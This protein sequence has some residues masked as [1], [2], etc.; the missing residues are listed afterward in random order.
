MLARG[1]T[2]SAADLKYFGERR[3][4]LVRSLLAVDVA[5]PVLTLLV[6]VLLRPAPATTLGL[7]ILAASPAAPFVLLKIESAGGRREY[8]TSLHLALALLA[9]VTTPATLALL[10]GFAGVELKVSA[11]A[12]AE[13]IGVSVLLPLLAGMLVRRLVPTASS[14]LVRPLETFAIGLQVLLIVAVLASTYHLLL[15][16]DIRSYLAIG[17]TVAA[18]LV[19]G[20]LL[21][22]GRQEENTALALESATRNVGLA[23]LIA[24]FFA[25]LEKALPVLVP[26][27]VIS[28]IVVAG[29]VQYR[30]RRRGQ[31]SPPESRPRR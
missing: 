11:F 12:V 25:P 27:A 2:T 4:L 30:K 17:A 20:H 13:Q 5:V 10:A 3:G 15:S 23:L 24:S 14:R 22:W 29:Y 8:A 7:L 21:G 26:Y 9:V 18:A 31:A 1:L 19:A 28:S 16:M 6:T